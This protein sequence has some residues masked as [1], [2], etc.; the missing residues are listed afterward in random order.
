MHF[1][2]LRV[3]IIVSSIVCILTVGI[4]SNMYLYNYLSGI[5]AEKADAVS[6]AHLESIKNRINQSLS[7]FYDL[8]YTCSSDFDIARTMRYS[9]LNAVAQKNSGLKAREKLWSLLESSSVK[10]YVT[11]IMVFNENGIIVQPGNARRQGSLQ[12]VVRIQELPLF[13]QLENGDE[14]QVFGASESLASGNDC[15]V[16]ISPVYDMVSMTNSGWLYME[17]NTRWIF[18]ETGSSLS[19]IFFVADNDGKV[20]SSDNYQSLE[21]YKTYMADADEVRIDKNTYKISSVPLYVDTLTLVNYSDIT[22]LSQ[23]SQP[24]FFTALV[25]VATS[26]V[27]AV[28]MS[29]LLSSIITRPLRRLM[30][31]IGKIAENDFTNDPEI[32]KGNDE[33]SQT[34]RMVN[35]M[36][37]SI[38]SLLEDTERMYIQRKNSEIALLQ[39][40][41]NPHFLYNTLDSIHWMAG[42]QKNTGI[43]TMTKGLSNLLKNLAKGIGDKITLGE[44]VSLLD[45]YVD[46]QLIRYTEV[47]QVVNN[48]PM[49]LYKYTITK[50]TLQPIVENSI[51]HG[52]EPKGALGLITLNAKRDGSDLLITVRDDGVGMTP[53]E[54]AKLKNSV[55]NPN[56]SGLSGIGVANV[57]S[58]LKLVYGEEYGLTIKSEKG[59]YTTVTIRIPMEEDNV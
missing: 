43:M 6:A 30:G 55:R 33:I 42:I 46:I 57:D 8:G 31:H 3:K 10:D 18:D 22:F 15:F 40:Q 48:I 26:F 54:L 36:T 27:V 7:R 59:M 58:R 51:F 38:K 37:S 9:R 21:L 32:E 14:L 35:Q 19:D 5:I 28:L 49:D 4:F 17:V 16:Y 12:D 20:F 24:I 41:I 39:S 56:P 29:V 13:K 50:F 23:D 1:R 11:T 53:E 45:S 44:E 52:I 34:G 25:V 47:F 2:S